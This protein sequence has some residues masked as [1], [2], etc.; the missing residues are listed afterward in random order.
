MGD[1]EFIRYCE[2][3]SETERAGFVPEHIARILRLAGRADDAKSWDGKPLQIISVHADV[4]HPLCEVA[5]AALAA[6][7]GHR[8]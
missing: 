5:R 8:G 4:M 2:T 3:H 7:G 6:E 1:L